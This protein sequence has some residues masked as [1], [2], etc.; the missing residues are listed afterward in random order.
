MLGWRWLGCSCY[1]CTDVDMKLCGNE[2]V[3]RFVEVT[4]DVDDKNIGKGSNVS[5]AA[6]EQVFGYGNGQ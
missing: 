5:S 3:H 2:D 4:Y 6:I 1:A